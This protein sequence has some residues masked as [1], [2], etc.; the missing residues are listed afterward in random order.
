VFYK[1]NTSQGTAY[2]SL[3]SGPYFPAIGD[4]SATNTW[5][6]SINF[7]QRPFSYTPPSGFKSLNTTNLPDST[8]V[9]GNQWMDVNLWT[10]NNSTNVIT[11]SGSMQPDFLWIK[12]RSSAFDNELYDSVRGVTKYLA[13]NT[14]AAEATETAGSG[15][16][17]FNSN[18]FTLG[19]AGGAYVNN[20]AL[21][22]VGWQW[23]ANGTPAV[24]NTAGSITSTVSASTTAGFS[25]VTYTGT[26]VVATIGH[27]LGVTPNMMI[28]KK[29]SSTSS[30]GVYHSSIGATGAVFLDTTGAT[31]TS[32][33]YF[34]NTAPTSSVFTVGGAISWN[35]DNGSTYV[36]YCFAEVA[37]FSK[38]G[39][40]TGNGSSDGPFVY[41]GFRPRFVMTKRSDS[42]TS[43]NWMITDS[44]RNTYNLA[45]EILIPNLPDAE[46]SQ[47]GIDMLSNGFKMRAS[48]GN[49]NT[50]GGTFIYAVFAENP[51]KNSLAR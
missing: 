49:R 35:S 1:N 43:G 11:N 10:G 37:G 44:A 13:S 41:T 42:S 15:V 22:F 36:A 14:T 6:G 50:N 30:W 32:S 51:F 5:S 8:I 21:T 47:D 9:Q 16:T 24:T 12:S 17:S 20:N 7:G 31:A 27:G 46:Y 39:S 33:G 48:T 29:R 18:G 40:Y 25:V 34:N 38:F 19:P 3:T 28:M 26:G 4:G 45:G 23:K 2:S